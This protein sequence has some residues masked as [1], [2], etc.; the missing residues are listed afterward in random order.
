MSGGF[1]AKTVDPYGFRT[2]TISSGFQPPFFFGGA[3]TPHDLNLPRKSFSGSGISQPFSAKQGCEVIRRGS[4]MI[5]RK[6][7]FN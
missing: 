6:L 7:P 3:Q 2:Q 5:P 4:T 1:N